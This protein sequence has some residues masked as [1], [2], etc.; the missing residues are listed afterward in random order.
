MSL[1]SSY[2][3]KKTTMFRNYLL[4][5]LRTLAR[6]R[7]YTFITAIGLSIGLATCFLI[8]SWVQFEKSYD[9]YFPESDRIYRVVTKWDESSEPGRATTYPMVR[10]RVLSQF[11]EVEA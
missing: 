10:T 7:L 11:P 9:N 4:S 5:T 1:S 6:E 2:L 3:G 8:Y